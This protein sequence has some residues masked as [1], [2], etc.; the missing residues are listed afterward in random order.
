MFAGH[1]K[2]LKNNLTFGRNHQ[3]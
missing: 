3:N 2:P 1:H